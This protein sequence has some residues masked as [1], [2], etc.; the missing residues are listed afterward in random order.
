MKKNRTT[1]QITRWKAILILL[2]TLVSATFGFGIF[3]YIQ[4]MQKNFKSNYFNNGKFK[5]ITP[6]DIIKK[7]TT[8]NTA[9]RWFFN[10]KNT[11]LNRK[12]HFSADKIPKMV[13][14]D[15]KIMWT[16][17]SS[18]YIE[19]EGKRFVIRPWK[20][21]VERLIIAAEQNNIKLSLPKPG[22]LLSENEFVINSKWWEINQIFLKP[23]SL[24]HNYN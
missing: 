8:L 21:P 15:L 7:G 1:K 9:K 12:F 18:V 2:G 5:N 6:V 16:S 3:D 4:N 24:P 20:E 17:H 10:K 22:Q 19:I 13:S 23:N 11:F 14:K